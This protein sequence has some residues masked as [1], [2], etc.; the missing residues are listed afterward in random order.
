LQEAE[1]VYRRILSQQPQHADAMHF[2]EC[3]RI[4][5]GEIRSRRI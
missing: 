5:P 2:L 3:W 1:R 4:R